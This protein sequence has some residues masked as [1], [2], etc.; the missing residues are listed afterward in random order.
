[1]HLLLTY[2]LRGSSSYP[3]IHVSA[4]RARH[5]QQTRRLPL[6]LSIDGTDRH[7]Q[8]DGQ[9]FD[10]FV[11]PTAHNEDRG[12]MQT[13]VLAV[14]AKK[15]IYDMFQNII[16]SFRLKNLT[17]TDFAMSWRSPISQYEI[18]ENAINLVK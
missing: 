14:F 13:P 9:T 18:S 7:K 15:Q 8:T 6:L 12:I 17:A 16:Q 4:A 11:T 3:S 5:Q 10:R 2:L 1:M